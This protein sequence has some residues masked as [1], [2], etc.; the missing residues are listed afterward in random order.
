MFI[1]FQVT[2]IVQIGFV[3]ETTKDMSSIRYMR[4]LIFAML[5]RHVSAFGMAET[6]ATIQRTQDHQ[7]FT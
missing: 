3:M 5:N 4:L 1:L 2:V 6:M 7:Q